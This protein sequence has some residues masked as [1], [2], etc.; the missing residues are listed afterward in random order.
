MKKYYYCYCPWRFDFLHNK[1]NIHYIC[2]GINERKDTTFFL[3]EFTP[4]VKQALDEYSYLY[5]ASDVI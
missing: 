3:F 5:P 1:K 4:E 2:K